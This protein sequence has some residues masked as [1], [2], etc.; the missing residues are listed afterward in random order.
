MNPGVVARELVLENFK[1]FGVKTRIP[2][3]TG[4]TTISGP[5][6]SGKSNLLDSLLFVLGLSSSKQLRAERLPDLITNQKGKTWAR[7][8]LRL[9][10]PDGENSNRIL[11]IAR[12]VRITKSG[13]TSTYYLDGSPANLQKVH[14]VLNELGIGSQGGNVVLQGDVTRIITMSRN[15]RRKLIDELA[16]VAEFDRKIEQAEVEIGKADRHM[17]DCRLIA[18]ELG[19]RLETLSEE[20]AQA[21]EHQKLEARREEW[22]VQLQ[23]AE[24]ADLARKAEGFRNDSE[25]LLEAEQKAEAELPKIAGRIEKARAAL[26]EAEDELRRMGEGEKLEKLRELEERKARATSLRAEVHHAEGLLREGE[27]RARSLDAGISKSD[28]EREAAL[29]VAREARAA[30]EV[31]RKK[32]SQAKADAGAARAEMKGVAAEAQ[33]RVAELHELKDQAREISVAL[34][35]ARVR[36]ENATANRDRLVEQIT[37]IDAELADLAKRLTNLSDLVGDADETRDALAREAA[38]SVELLNALKH[39]RRELEDRKSDLEDEIRP[40]I[41]QVGAAEASAKAD[42]HGAALA[43]LRQEGIPGVIGDVQ[44]LLDFPADL[45]DAIAAACGGRLRNVVVEDDRVAARCIETL[46]R[47]RGPRATFLPLNKIRGRGASGFLS[48]PGL[49]DYLIN[50]VHF[51]EEHLAAMEYVFGTTVLAEDLD[52]ARRHLGKFRMVTREGDLLDKSGAMTGGGKKARLSGGGN[53]AKLRAKLSS[54]ENE[55]RRV[56]DEMRL[57]AKRIHDAEGQRDRARENLSG[58]DKD[59]A[60]DHKDKESLLDLRVKLKKRRGEVDGDRA[61]AIGHLEAAAREEGRLTGELEALQGRISAIEAELEGGTAATLSARIEELEARAQTH[62]A[63]GTRLEEEARRK[64][65]EV[66]FLDRSL[67]GWRKELEEVRAREVELSKRVEAGRTEA[68][69]AEVRVRELAK[70]LEGLT[71]E[72]EA[73]RAQREERSKALEGLF[74]RRASVEAKVEVVRGQLQGVKAKI[75]ELDTARAELERKLAERGE[76]PEGLGEPPSVAKA[77]RELDQVLTALRELGPVNLLAVQQYDELEGRRSELEERLT[78]LETE[79][80]ELTERIERFGGLKK[81]AFLKAFDAVD[82]NF[83]EI[84][85]QLSEGSGELELEDRDDPFA[86]GLTLKAQPRNKNLERLEALSGGEKSLAALAFIFSLQGYRPAPFYVFDEVDMFL[87]GRNTELLAD[88]IQRRSEGTQFLVVS[89]RKAM[90]KRS[91]RTIGVMPGP[92]GN[93]KVTGVEYVT[94]DAPSDDGG[95]EREAASA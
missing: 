2:L 88:M 49:V 35:E 76:L 48:E 53:L 60:R 21:L 77:R 34:S 59:L 40:L 75:A 22:E 20:R 16:G 30:A 91:C 71:G 18:N 11:E 47:K 86:G 14:D 33:A 17:E 62:E 50:R 26:A 6:G 37:A 65:V 41:R 89:L 32:G 36:G 66:Q 27:R 69:E 44:S 58:L 51:D 83:R 64:D 73:L 23:R 81:E 29:E 10:V 95:D 38:E 42:G 80:R 15:D 68:D 9:Q 4:F 39:R 12:K 85:A 78:T 46:R 24:I 13:Y 55:V 57:V 25:E 3:R 87:D 82:T 5:N 7:V 67:E 70:E 84:Y 8:G 72:I 52:S 43:V 93:T 19:A 31:E 90:L 61:E 56:L 92:G 63:E 79:K 1:S 74:S 28:A 45:G 94:D 54:K